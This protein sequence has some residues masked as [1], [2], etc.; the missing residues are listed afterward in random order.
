VT[1]QEHPYFDD[2]FYI[3]LT[4]PDILKLTSYIDISELLATSVP[5]EI[6]LLE[7]KD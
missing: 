6:Q 3:S 5:I 2:A 7:V 4:D 1:A